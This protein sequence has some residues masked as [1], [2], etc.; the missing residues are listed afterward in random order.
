MLSPT[1]SPDVSR[2]AYAAW[3]DTTNGIAQHF[4]SFASQA[5]VVSLAG[6]LP[7]AEF[8]PA[9]A[10]ARATQ[11]A[12][13]TRGTSILEY[14]DVEGL[15]DL[16]R[17][18][19]AQT[20]KDT[21]GQF[22]ADNVLIT[23]GSS[24]ALDLLGKVFID[25]GDVIV[26]Q[27]PTYLGALDAWRA[28]LPSYE[29]L[30]WEA[31]VDVADGSTPQAMR[32]ADTRAALRRAKF[33]YTVPNYSNP[34]GVLVGRE[35]RVALLNEVV[36]AGTWLVEDD[37]YKS[38][39]FDGK[40][41]PSILSLD[42]ARAGSVAN[43]SAAPA[44]YSGPVIS[45]GTLSKSIAPGLR[46]GWIVAEK[47]LIQ[48]L[49]LA[50]Q[51]S[52]LS[53]S[54]MNQAVAFELMQD[55]VDLAVAAQAVPAYR[56]R[57]DILCAAANEWLSEWFEWEV[58]VGGMFIWMRARHNAI[59]TDALYAFAVAHHVAFVP[60]SVFDHA[61]ADRFGMRLNFTR[62]AP[63]VLIE[64]VRRLHSAVQDYLAATMPIGDRADETM[65]VEA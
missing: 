34:T 40:C 22:T 35:Q 30:D 6:G 64:G 24:Q 17:L 16:R 18:I 28:R 3:L 26:T 39:T 52:M 50:K 58:P 11:R 45:L 47:G 20:A 12:M 4:L 42:V 46:I 48:Q 38:I 55:G 57:R 9:T 23:T 31:C 41:E 43:V 54:L 14:G 51:A 44:T 33:V 19:A 21:G 62:S 60:S 7:A 27:T 29:K 2:P 49:A 59:D 15:P 1:P 32:A 25:T 65:P 56:E 10:I 63:D 53:S 13:E 36:D 61:A 8:Y 37:P 5:N